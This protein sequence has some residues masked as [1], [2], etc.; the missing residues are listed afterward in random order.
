MFSLSPSMKAEAS[1]PSIGRSLGTRF[2]VPVIPA[3]VG[4]QSPAA[5]VSWVTMPAGTLPGQRIIAGTRW[6][7][8]NGVFGKSPRQGPL[9]PG[10]TFGE[11]PPPALSLLRMAMAPFL[12][13]IKR[14]GVLRLNVPA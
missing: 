5:S 3:N 13:L 9:E 2:D 1:T 7:P 8:S 6:L 14:F 11:Y 4:S 10:P 12:M